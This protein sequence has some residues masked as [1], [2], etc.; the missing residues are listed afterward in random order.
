MREGGCFLSPVCFLHLNTSPSLNPNQ[1]GC[2]TRTNARLEFRLRGGEGGTGG[3]GMTAEVKEW[4]TPRVAGRKCVL[5][6]R[7]SVSQLAGGAGHLQKGGAVR[8]TGREIHESTKQQN[9]EISEEGSASWRFRLHETWK[10]KESG[11]LTEFSQSNLCLKVW[12][13]LPTAFSPQ[14]FSHLRTH[15]N[16]EL[17]HTRMCSLDY[18]IS[19]FSPL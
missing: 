2:H 17:L 11:W 4:Q 9:S 15:C 18:R 3:R 7:R 5:K 12:C 1:S 6:A 14:C 19:G 8:G 10:V 16:L 13:S